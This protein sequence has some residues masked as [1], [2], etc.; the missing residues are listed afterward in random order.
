MAVLS[1]ASKG[2]RGAAAWPYCR[3]NDE[4]NAAKKDFYG[5]R[6]EKS[7]I[8]SRSRRLH[9]SAR[10][11]KLFVVGEQ[12][13]GT[14]LRQAKRPGGVRANYSLGGATVDLHSICCPHMAR[15]M[16]IA[17]T[18]ALKLD[19]AGVDL[20]FLP[21]QQIYRVRSEQD[22]RLECDRRRS[23]STSQYCT[24]PN[25]RRGVQLAQHGR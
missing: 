12:V 9:R 1:Q 23:A 10:M 20:L 5:A 4:F 16:A 18:K 2:C 6:S 7:I 17:A 3:T 22:R 15:E 14:M 25:R 19:Y 24:T 11:C 13:I 21:G 8:S